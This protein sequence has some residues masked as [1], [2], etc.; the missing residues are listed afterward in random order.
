[1]EEAT[2]TVFSVENK[3]RGAR[4][5]M[6]MKNLKTKASVNDAKRQR[7]RRLRQEFDKRSS[8]FNFVCSEDTK[9]TTEINTI[10]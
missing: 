7:R 9:L 6:L 1:M 2:D 4:R 8:I 10:R 5:W 3:G